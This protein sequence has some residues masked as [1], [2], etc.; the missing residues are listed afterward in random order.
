MEQAEYALARPVCLSLPAEEIDKLLREKDGRCALV[1]LALQRAG[2][3]AVTAESVGLTERELRDV[4]A[5]LER[6]GL[7]SARKNMPLPPADELPQYTAEDLVRRSREDAAF[8]GVRMDTERLYGRKL[9]TPETRTLLGMYDYLGFPAE[10]L[11]ELIHHVFEEFRAENGPG[12]V[13]TMRMIEKEAYVWAQ[14]EVLTLELAEAYL[15]RR[16]QRKERTAQALETVQVRGRA[17]TPTER[18]YIESWL[19]MGFDTEAIAEAYDRTV[20]ST[21]GLKWPYMNKILLSWHQKGLHTPEE[22][23]QGDPRGGARRSAAAVQTSAAP[24]NDLARAEQMLRDMK[25]RKKE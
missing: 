21:G 4:L 22:I 16:Q 14:H 20:V 11:L 1:Y 23:A 12:R 5:K 8:Q 19:D 18:K 7:V 9:T 2:E 13:P 3:R 6:L 10:V 24:R 15:E 17:P 25:K